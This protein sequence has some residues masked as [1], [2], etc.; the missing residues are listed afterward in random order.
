MQPPAPTVTVLTLPV[1]QTLAGSGWCWSV[2]QGD[3]AATFEV[4]PQA[5]GWQVKASF[6]PTLTA[7]GTWN[8]KLGGTAK[9][10]TTLATITVSKSSVQGG[11]D[12]AYI[13]NP[14]FKLNWEA[15]NLE[16]DPLFVD[17]A[18]V[19]FSLAAGSPC[20]NAG[21][22]AALPPDTFDLDGDGDVT[23]ALPL[24]FA[25]APRVAGSPPIV[26]MGAYEFPSR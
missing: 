18:Q 11:E 14:T 25:G 16:V 17:P 26:D 23:E 5:G 2:I 21:D 1:T 24:D 6:V 4:T 9:G 22:T 20:I 19:D 8:G 3:L 10:S 15:G 7:L 12:E 13:E